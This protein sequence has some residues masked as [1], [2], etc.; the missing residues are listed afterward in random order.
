MKGRK[1]QKGNIWKLVQMGLS[2]S[3]Q[4]FAEVRKQGLNKDCAVWKLYKYPVS[5]RHRYIFFFAMLYATSVFHFQLDLI[6]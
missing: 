3:V 1:P 4:F 5:V 2:Y 6:K